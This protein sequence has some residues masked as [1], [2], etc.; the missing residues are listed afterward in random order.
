LQGDDDGRFFYLITVTALC[1]CV[2]LAPPNKPSSCPQLTNLCND[3]LYYELM[4][5]QCPKTCG[6]CSKNITPSVCQDEALPNAPSQCPDLFYLCNNPF[7]RNLMTQQ[8]PK[9]CSRC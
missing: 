4:S 6:Y 8:C 1:T 9:T 7:Y 3:T 2:D 5:K